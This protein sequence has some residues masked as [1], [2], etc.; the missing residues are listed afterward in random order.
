MRYYN[1]NRVK[2]PFIK[3]NCAA[4]PETDRKRAVRL[5]EGRLHRGQHRQDRPVRDGG[6]RLAAARRNRR[7]AA[8]PCGQKLLG[9]GNGCQPIGSDRL[10]HVDFRLIC[11]TNI[12][13]DVA[14]REGSCARTCISVS[15]PSRCGC[16]R[17]AKRSRTFRFS[18][19][20]SCPSSISAT[21]RTSGPSRGCVSPVDSKPVAG[22]RARASRTPSRARC[23]RQQDWRNSPQ[24]SARA[25]SRGGRR[26]RSSRSRRTGRW[27]KLKKMAILQTLQRT[28]WNKQR[29]WRKSS[30]C[31]GRR[32]TAR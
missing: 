4:I 14:L 6:G 25:D 13:L 11:A 7:D 1:S 26:L 10:V 29:A 8:V 28:N 17:C 27:P 21:R 2:G 24:R 19:I 16:R 18:A 31:T 9:S 5:Q 3:I 22:Q 20:T 12:D 23:A 32:S 15:I 30:G